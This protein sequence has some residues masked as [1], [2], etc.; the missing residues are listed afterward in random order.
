M[1]R[2]RTVI[3][4]HCRQ[5]RTATPAPALFRLL[6][7]RLNAQ[8]RMGDAQRFEFGQVIQVLLFAAAPVDGDITVRVTRQGGQQNRAHV[9]EACTTSD[10]DQWTVFVIT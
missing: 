2:Q 9:G 1:P 10:Q 8:V 6:N 7:H 3:L 4:Q 5:Y